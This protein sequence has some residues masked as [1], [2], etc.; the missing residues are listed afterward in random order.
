VNETAFEGSWGRPQRDGPALRA[1]ALS[2]YA[3]YLLSHSNTSYV[4][5]TL[6]PVIEKDL[7]YVM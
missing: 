1:T 6:Y 5:S 3:T 4:S 2:T 7:N